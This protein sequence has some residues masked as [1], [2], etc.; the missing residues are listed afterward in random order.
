MYLG[1]FRKSSII[2]HLAPPQTG[3]GVPAAERQRLNVFAELRSH[4]LDYICT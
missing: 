3:V 4:A 1:S 2:T